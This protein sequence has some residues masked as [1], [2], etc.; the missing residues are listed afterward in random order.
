MAN[1]RN[2]LN[3]TVKINGVSL[4]PLAAVDTKVQTRY[5]YYYKVFDMKNQLKNFDEVFKK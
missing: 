5:H 2:G 4:K 3:K 1:L